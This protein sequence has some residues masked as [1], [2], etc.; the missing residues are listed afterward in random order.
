MSKAIP[1]T[2]SCITSYGTLTFVQDYPS[3]SQAIKS[4]KEHAR[5]GIWCSTVR[6]HEHPQRTF[7]FF[8]E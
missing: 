7:D 1:C 6:T 5:D 3:M 2:L 4:A 8:R